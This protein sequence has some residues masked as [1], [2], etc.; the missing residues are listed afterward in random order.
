MFNNKKPKWYAAGLH[1]HCCQC[2]QCCSGPGEG[3]IWVTKK[4]IEMIADY[5]KITEDQLRDQYLTRIGIRTSII[6]EPV[7]KDCI[8]LER[9][10]GQKKCR[11]YEVRPNQC[12]VWPFWNDNLKSPQTWNQAAQRCPGVNKGRLYSFEEIEQLRKQTKWWKD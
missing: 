1:F 4:E 6:E 2:G 10:E 5:L 8:F 7:S 12:R 11:I 9:I 3:F